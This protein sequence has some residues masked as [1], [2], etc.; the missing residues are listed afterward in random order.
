MKKFTLILFAIAILTGVSVKGAYAQVSVRAHVSVEVI[1]S[2]TATETA[3]LNFGRISP[4]NT[5]G[6]V[7][8]T[9]E[10]TRSATGTV[11]LSDGSFNAAVF[12]LTGQDAAVVTVTLPSAPVLLS[13]SSTGKTME[14]GDWISYP[15]AGMGGVLTKGGLSLKVGATLKVG[16]KNDNPVGLYAGTYVITFSYN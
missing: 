15:A 9:P 3:A 6:V 5:G 2:I 11:A 1:Q 4:E 7:K 10:G 12:Y 16:N 13:N 8:L 14:V